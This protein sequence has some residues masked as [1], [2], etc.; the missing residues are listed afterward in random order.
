MR[1]D[2]AM[3]QRR[4]V[5]VQAQDAGKNFG[6]FQPRH[7][8]GAGQKVRPEKVPAAGLGHVLVIVQR[9]GTVERDVARLAAEFLPIGSAIKTRAADRLDEKPVAG[10]ARAEGVPDGAPA[11]LVGPER[12]DRRAV[13]GRAWR[14]FHAGGYYRF[15]A[16][17]PIHV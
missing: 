16:V 9:V 11:V 14:F 2:H 12:N 7:P 17:A 5:Q 15:L 1:A 4:F 13:T 10:A 8:V 6:P 3:A